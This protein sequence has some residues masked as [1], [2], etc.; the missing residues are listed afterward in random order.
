MDVSWAVFGVGV[1]LS[2]YAYLM[3]RVERKEKEERNRL[4][5]RACSRS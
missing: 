2:G 3:M 1:L 4:I 5:R